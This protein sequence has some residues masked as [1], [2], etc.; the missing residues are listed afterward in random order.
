METIDINPSLHKLVH[1]AAKGDIKAVTH[2]LINNFQEAK[3]VMLT[4]IK[5]CIKEEAALMC[6]K[7]EDG[8]TLFK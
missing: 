3:N 1:L 8:N 5:T 6:K 7:R 4:S 2:Y